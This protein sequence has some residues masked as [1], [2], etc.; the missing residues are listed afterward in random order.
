MRIILEILIS[1]SAAL[2]VFSILVC[3]AAKKSEKS[4]NEILNKLKNEKTN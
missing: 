1:I 3:Y 2:L 4:E